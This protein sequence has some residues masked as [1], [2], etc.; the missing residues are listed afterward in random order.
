MERQTMN[1]RIEAAQERLEQAASKWQ[2]ARKNTVTADRFVS[3]C[4]ELDE[5]ITNLHKEVSE[6]LKEKGSIPR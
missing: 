4:A 2:Q 1:G 3:A 5:A 6:Y